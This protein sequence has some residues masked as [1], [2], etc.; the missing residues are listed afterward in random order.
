MDQPFYWQQRFRGV[1]EKRLKPAKPKTAWVAAEDL[2]EGDRFE[3]V[4]KDWTVEAH[5]VGDH[6]VDVQ[7]SNEARNTT[8]KFLP[9]ESVK[10][11]LPRA[12]VVA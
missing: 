8:V 1:M 12:E 7:V 3:F 4:G 5:A 11:F 9:F 2:R 6:L 10:V